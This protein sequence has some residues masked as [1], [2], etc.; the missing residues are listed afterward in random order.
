MTITEPMPFVRDRLTWIG[1][2]MLAY[3]S[4]FISAL[5]PIVPFL[6][7]EW[8][9]NYTVSGLHLS[10][11]AG[12]VV[13][14]GLVA[15]RVTQRLGRRA[16]L[17]GGAT[18]V[19]LGTVALIVSQSVLVSLP[20]MFFMGLSGGLLL[21]TV[22]A[23]LAEHH[24]AQRTVALAE[25][26]VWASLTGTLAPLLIGATQRIGLGWRSALLL[27]IA[28]FIV[29]GSM[30]GR[31]S[32]QTSS[33]GA[34]QEASARTLPR[35]FWRFWLLIFV[36]VAIEWCMLFWAADFLT[37]VRAIPPASAATAISTFLGAMLLG[38]FVGSRLTRTIS[39]ARL[40]IIAL[41]I[42]AVGFPIFWLVPHAGLSI[43]GLFLCGLGVANLYPLG[44][45]LA[46]DAVPLHANLASARLAVSSSSAVLLLPLL[47]G[48]VADRIGIQRAI[49]IVLVLVA[50][51]LSLLIR[52]RSAHQ[53]SATFAADHVQCG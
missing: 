6:R 46:M 50:L 5:G 20:S 42:V 38:R 28:V 47:L 25:A 52:P 7:A 31:V 32:L 11:F 4:Y 53:S 35:V 3:Y 10:A 14:T 21:I 48:T 49:A 51:A 1:Y 44:L 40:L 34:D 16:A 17:W 22:Q 45:S 18:G 2:A 27:A 23:L 37:N 39:S 29:M 26:N 33:V 8:S 24:G 9:L 36:V 15:E 41:G 13:L 43:V 19:A 12:G 30:W